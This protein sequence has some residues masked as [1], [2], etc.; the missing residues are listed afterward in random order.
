MS[1]HECLSW[2]ERANLPAHCQRDCSGASRASLRRNQEC[3]GDVG[4]RRARTHH[5]SQDALPTTRAQSKSRMPPVHLRL[6]AGSFPARRN[7]TIA[8]AC[9]MI[10]AVCGAE[11]ALACVISLFGPVCS[12]RPVLTGLFRR[13]CSVEKSRRN[14]EAFLWLRVSDLSMKI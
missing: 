8:V 1:R 3:W 13:A 2:A 7:Q 6:P 12:Y 9:S 14:V 10:E 11:S 5:R 4:V